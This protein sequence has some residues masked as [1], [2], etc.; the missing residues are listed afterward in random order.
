M[1]GL[2]KSTEV[3]RQLPKTQLYR[4]FDWKPAQRAAFD[5]DV[6]RMD[7]VNWLSPKTLPALAPS[8]SVREIYVVK[9]EMKRRD[10]DKKNLSLLA[11][12]IPQKMI[13]ALHHEGK[14]QVAVYHINLFVTEWMDAEQADSFFSI[15]TF[16]F[17]SLW[18]ELVAKT[19]NV[20]V[21]AENSLDKQ[22]KVNEEQAKLLAKISQLESKMNATKQPKKKLEIYK[23]IQ[24]IKKLLH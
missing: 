14:I 7:F 15:A 11:K 10:Y 2:P 4:Q 23:Q 19:G 22:I 6:A 1:L 3:E 12:S 18:E 9:L 8:D 17:D 13:F 21:D 24:D 5:A 20:K 16:G